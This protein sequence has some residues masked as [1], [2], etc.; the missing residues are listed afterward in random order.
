MNRVCD[1]TQYYDKDSSIFLT[2]AELEG[3]QYTDIVDL[4]Y[5][6]MNETLLGIPRDYNFHEVKIYLYDM[7]DLVGNTYQ[8]AVR[9]E[10]Q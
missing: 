3:V 7:N 6:E 8:F 5:Y 2:T 9:E 1:H 10:G 4:S